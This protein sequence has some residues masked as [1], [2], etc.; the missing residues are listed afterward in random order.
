[1]SKDTGFDGRDIE[2]HN[3]GFEKDIDYGKTR[4]SFNQSP[5]GLDCSTVIGFISSL[6]EISVQESLLEDSI[7]KNLFTLQKTYCALKNGMKLGFSS[8]TTILIHILFCYVFSYEFLID[9]FKDNEL[10]GLFIKYIPAI[11]TIGVTIYISN[12]SKY[13]VGD[14]TARALKVFYLG[15]MFST[16]I[17]GFVIFISFMY[18]EFLLNEISFNSTMTYAKNI[19]F[20]SINSIYYITIIL[21]LISSLLPFLYYGFRK[22]LFSTSEKSKYDRY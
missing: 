5:L 14:Y 9:F 10:I 7:D 11:I 21:I 20:N 13:A 16:V 22:I 3:K 1:M 17:V 18:L 19:F 6:Q 12:L 15:K 2:W 8:S 4:D